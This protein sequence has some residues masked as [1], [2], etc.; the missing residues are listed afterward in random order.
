MLGSDLS[1]NCCSSLQPEKNIFLKMPLVI[2]IDFFVFIKDSWIESSDWLSSFLLQGILWC[3]LLDRRAN[4][5]LLTRT[6][7][8][9]LLL[10]LLLVVIGVFVRLVVV[11][12]VVVVVDDDGCCIGNDDDSDVEAAALLLLLL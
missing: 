10:L 2:V 8:A 12:V 6:I 4:R 3:N 7:V 9:A 5:N 1:H 11:W